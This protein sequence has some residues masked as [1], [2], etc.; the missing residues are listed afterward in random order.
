M[1]IQDI[2]GKISQSQKGTSYNPAHMG[3]PQQTEHAHK[4]IFQ[5]QRQNKDI[6]FH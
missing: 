4:T 3:C 2:L 6:F 1:S 5:D